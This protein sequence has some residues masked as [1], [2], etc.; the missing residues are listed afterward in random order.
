MEDAKKRIKR[1]VM[2][3]NAEVKDDLYLDFTVT[4]VINRALIYTNRLQLDE[5]D[6]LP[7]VLET[8]LATVVVRVHKTVSENV[9]TD[10]PEVVKVQ[11]GQQSVAYGSSLTS[12]LASTSDT[13]LF[14]SVKELLNK[15]RI[16]TVVEN[17]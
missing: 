16:P 17:T 13:D 11:D 12:Y 8:A 4:D 6:Q 3:L 1:Y 15:F 5:E 9:E 7:T 2:V 14:L 10:S